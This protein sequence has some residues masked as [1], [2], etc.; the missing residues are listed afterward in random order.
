M[1]DHRPTRT[2]FFKMVLFVAV[3]IATML[4]L[5]FLSGC[6]TPPL[7]PQCEYEASTATAAVR[8]GAA[9]YQFQN[10]YGLCM[11]KRQHG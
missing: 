4:G 2:E 1:S 7:D 8:G 5:M 3:F 9:V 6:A 11:R 10:I